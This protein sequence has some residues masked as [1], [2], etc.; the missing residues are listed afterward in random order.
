MYGIGESLDTAVIDGVGIGAPNVQ[1]MFRVNPSEIVSRGG[2]LFN[3]IV[4]GIERSAKF[5]TRTRTVAE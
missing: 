5:A 3:C 1:L 2:G 4:I